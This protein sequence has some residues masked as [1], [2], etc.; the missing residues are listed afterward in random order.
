MSYDRREALR[1]VDGRIKKARGRKQRGRVLALRKI[2]ANIK[3]EIRDTE[4]ARVRLA[5]IADAPEGLVQ[6]EELLKRLARLE[7]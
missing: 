2:R 1:E 3:H 7:T 6:D 4:I 5:E